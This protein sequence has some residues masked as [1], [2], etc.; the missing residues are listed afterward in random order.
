M[1]GISIITSILCAVMTWLWYSKS[2]ICDKIKVKKE[3]DV[4]GE[5]GGE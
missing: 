4:S 5:E 2:V 3:K 1:I